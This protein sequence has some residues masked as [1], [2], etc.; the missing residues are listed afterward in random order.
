MKLILAQLLKKIMF[1]Y[2]DN[3]DRKGIYFPQLSVGVPVY[4]SREKTPGA[5]GGE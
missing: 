1:S 5:G 3:N 2:L 4:C